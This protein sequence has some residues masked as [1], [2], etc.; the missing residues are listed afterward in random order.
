[1]TIICR[2]TIIE[3]IK[4]AAQS[5]KKECV[6]I[7]P[8]VKDEALKVV[9]NELPPSVHVR[10]LTKADENDVLSGV[11]D[12]SCWKLIWD[13][14]GE[15][16][17]LD[18]LH[19]KYYRFDEKVF[20]GS[21]NLTQMA[22]GLTTPA[23]NELMVVLDHDEHCYDSENALW[24]QAVCAT[25]DMLE[26]L[27]NN[28]ELCRKERKSL[29]LVSQ[30]ITFNELIKGTSISQSKSNSKIR[31]L[32]KP[33]VSAFKNLGKKGIS[34]STALE[35][36]TTDLSEMAEKVSSAGT[37]IEDQDLESRIE[38]LTSRGASFFVTRDKNNN[39]LP[40]VFLNDRDDKRH[41]GCSFQG[42]TKQ[43]DLKTPEEVLGALITNCNLRCRWNGDGAG[44][45]KK[46]RNSELVYFYGRNITS[47]L[48]NVHTFDMSNDL[49]TNLKVV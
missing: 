19:A 41:I 42:S 31:K 20:I 40:C 37:I 16:K 29:P 15:V 46:P 32:S 39:L 45:F 8:F 44:L 17:V 26:I 47:F 4:N 30:P 25:P 12:L 13:R 7:A 34:R 21:A 10:L 35:K 28:V 43:A 18:K 48:E 24:D 23:N 5:T 49:L 2:D 33:L 6:L 9:I 11:N 22:L 1:M 36:S 27:A 3:A 14:H 38:E